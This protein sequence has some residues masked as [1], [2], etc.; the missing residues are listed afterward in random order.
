MLPAEYMRPN[1]PWRWTTGSK[2]VN[3][4]VCLS[5][6][7]VLDFARQTRLFDVINIDRSAIDT[8][9]MTIQGRKQHRLFYRA[10]D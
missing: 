10:R 4:S 7:F 1:V 2:L 8:F 5:E 3:L 9:N 6:A